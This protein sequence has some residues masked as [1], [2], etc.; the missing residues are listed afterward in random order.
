M[1]ILQTAGSATLCFLPYIAERFPKEYLFAYY[2][3]DSFSAL[4]PAV[5]ALIQGVSVSESCK[6]NTVWVTKFNNKTQ[7]SFSQYQNMLK[8]VNLEP[9]FSVFN[10]FMVLFVI[11]CLSTLVF[12]LIDNLPYVQQFWKEKTTK[13]A[14]EE[15]EVCELDSSI[16]PNTEKAILLIMN[17]LVTF[18][19]FGFMPGKKLE[20]QRKNFLCCFFQVLYL[21]FQVFNHIQR[22]HTAI[23]FIVYLLI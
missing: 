21:I 7:T 9:N 13:A 2:I 19:F 4:I 3:G 16:G 6:E 15:F 1:F 12:V 18:F 17:F 20:L 10:F 8:P 11:T 22:Y 5:L 14:E 23:W